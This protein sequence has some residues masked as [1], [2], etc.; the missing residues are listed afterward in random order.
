VS[1]LFAAWL[2][3][4]ISVA[5]EVVGNV[6]LRYAN[7]FNR[8][9]AAAVAVTFFLLS[10]WLMSVTMRKIELG[11]TYAVWAASSTA[12]TAWVGIGFYNESLTTSKVAGVALVVVGVIVLS[13]G[14]R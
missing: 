4:A 5:S 13:S 8:P 7:G 2:L 6:A 11:V 3:L 12:I 10:I 1:P 9:I 14:G